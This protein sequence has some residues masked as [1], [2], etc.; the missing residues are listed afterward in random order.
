MFNTTNHVSQTQNVNVIVPPPKPSVT[1]MEIRKR[2]EGSVFI[3]CMKNDNIWKGLFYITPFLN[4]SDLSRGKFYP[5]CFEKFNDQIIDI[6]DGRTWRL[7]TEEKDR[8]RRQH[9]ENREKIL[10]IQAVDVVQ[11]RFLDENEVI[12]EVKYLNPAEPC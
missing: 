1:R 11:L 12:A 4:R 3:K 2:E 6:Y 7:S 8:V 5:V 10:R 9:Y